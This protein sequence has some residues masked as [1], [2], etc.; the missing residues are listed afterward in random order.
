MCA[1]GFGVFSCTDKYDLDTEQPSGLNSI[2]GYLEDHG[3]FSTAMRLI[4]DLDEKETLSRTGSRTMFVADDDA[5]RAFFESNPWGVK[6][7]EDLTEAQKKLLLRSSVIENPFSTSMLSTAV[8]PVKG[9]VCRRASSITIYDSVMSIP[10]H[11]VLADKVLP[12][13]DR[14]NEIRANHDSIVLFTDNSVASPI[15][16]FTSKFL[17]SN[18]IPSTDIDFIYNQTVGTRLADDVY[19]N[20]A[21][22]IDANVF[23]KNG[24]I[25]KV[26]RVILPLDNMAEIIRKKPQASIYSSIVERFAAPEYSEADTRAYNTNKGT[27]VDSVFIKRYFSDRTFG[28]TSA[29]STAYEK[30]KNGV[31]ME[32]NASLK[33]DP[34]WNGYIPGVA[35]DRDGMQED[36]GVM[37][38]PSDKA[39]NEWWNSGYGQVIK[40]FYG[41]I[42]ATPSSTLAELVRVNQLVSFIQSVP[43]R[44]ADILNDANEPLGIKEADVDSV[45]LACNGVVYL[46]NKVF[47]P[48]SYSSVLFPAVLDTT[49]F[50]TIANAIENLQYKAYLNSMVAQYTFLLPTNDGMLT[51]IDPVSYGRTNGN[52]DVQLWEIYIA[53]PT[54]IASSAIVVD[55]YEAIIADGKV[56]K[57]DDNYVRMS[58]GTGAYNEGKHE[59]GHSIILDRIYDLLDNIIITE[60]YQPG[61]KYYRTKGRTFVRVDGNSVG[62]NVYGS[63]Q[64]DCKSPIS[65]SQTYNMENGT[66]LVLDGVPMSTSNSVAKLLK[67]HP[68]TF[69]DFYQLLE[70]A[71]AIYKSYSTSRQSP[72]VENS[73]IAGDQEYGN[74]FNLKNGKTVGA[75]DVDPSLTKATYLLNNYHYTIYAPTNAAMEEAYRLGLPKHEDL[76]N[77]ELW[78]EAFKEMDEEEQNALIAETGCCPGDS[79]AR[80]REVMLDF[81]KYHIQDNSLFLDLGFDA[82]TY[83]SGKTSLQPATDA[84]DDGGSYNTGKYTPGRPYKIEVESISSTG[85]TIRDNVGNVRHVVTDGNLY[86]LMAREYWY[87]GAN[88]K[89]F[90]NVD[91]YKIE[92]DNSSF[93][94]VHAIDGPLIYADGQHLC[95]DGKTIDP[96]QF[97]YK[98][99]EIETGK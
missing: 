53:D 13:N 42:E 19:I 35:N 56:Y 23:C 36:M 55:V 38:V 7:Y 31:S 30:D 65:V 29:G 28:S 2:Y 69:S 5:F 87:K 81:V 22:V 80:I 96:N 92:L 79:A 75:E 89:P 6:S 57:K 11:S 34:G 72:T 64:Q 50:K 21:K 99:R 61:K 90:E 74:L 41:T 86:N 85:M 70:D 27:E 88:G 44:F 60:A 71:N 40:N 54:E 17:S 14:F 37:I 1:A 63:L 97:I 51:Y 43:S 66:S 10:T 52:K 25:H 12:A 58:G 3:N 48:M 84:D 24:F 68:E 83:Y 16:A 77:A 73:R 49:H 67:Q 76:N 15:L 91:P 45:F 8:G 9:E 4:E 47:A 46:T 94:V 33:F 95:S 98:Y 62:S 59:G 82:G 18:K 78:D 32:G 26:D 39:M 20:N 93:V